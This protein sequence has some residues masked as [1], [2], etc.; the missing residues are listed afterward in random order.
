MAA[1]CGAN[2]TAVDGDHD[3]IVKLYRRLRENPASINPLVVD[4]GNPSPAIGY[5][6]VERSSFLDRS[7]PDCVMALALIHHLIVS[8][9]MSLDAICEQMHT[10]TQKDLILEFV[11][12][13]DNMFQRLMKFRVDLF[14]DINL[15][16]CIAAFEKRFDIKQQHDIPGSKRTLL[17][18]SK[19]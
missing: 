8:A 4:L 16:N 5:M 9:N 15:E 12:T 17:L 1:E 14:Q 3:A 11:P 10:M 13:D 6:N 7:K 19:K 2:V 18:L